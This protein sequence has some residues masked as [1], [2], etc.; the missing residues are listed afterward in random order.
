MSE[1]C[2]WPHCA[3]TAKDQCKG[4]GVRSDAIATLTARVKE[5]EAALN[6]LTTRLYEDLDGG[7]KLRRGEVDKARAALSPAPMEKT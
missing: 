3:H 4:T 2:T 7:R 5:L 6:R 1:T